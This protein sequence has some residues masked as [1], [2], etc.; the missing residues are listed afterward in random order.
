[1]EIECRS[2]GIYRYAGV[3][4]SVHAGFMRA[5]SKGSCFHERIRGR[6]PDTRIR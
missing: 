5:P 3:P 4:E 6:Y 1:L 2:G